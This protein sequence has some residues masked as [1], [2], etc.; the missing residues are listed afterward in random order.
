MR[1]VLTSMFVLL[2]FVASLVS[3]PC[4]AAGLESI[5][6]IMGAK[7]I[8]GPY[9]PTAG[10]IAAAFNRE[11][12]GN[13]MRITIRTNL[14][15]VTIL[16]SVTAGDFEFGVVPL[17]L[18]HQAYNGLGH[19]EG[20]PQTT[21][22]SVL[23]VQSECLAIV[24][25]GDSGIRTISDLEGRHILTGSPNSDL[26]V[27][28]MQILD[29]AGMHPGANFQIRQESPQVA[30]QLL[31]DD[32]IDAFFYTMG[33][34]NRDFLELAA[35][36]KGLFLV[37]LADAGL[38]RLI[39]GSPFL[40]KVVVKAGSDPNFINTF[41]TEIVGIKASL[42]TSLQVPERVVYQVAKA[43]FDNLDHFRNRYPDTVTLTRSTLVKGLVTPPHPGAAALFDALQIKPVL[44]SEPLG[45]GVID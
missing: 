4:V 30:P 14:S 20:R 8:T 22:R 1:D 36:R 19:W 9:Y 11:Q 12:S 3:L 37:S 31:Q 26:H 23:N 18:V 29:A 43:V 7:R 40:E 38:D 42:V 5:H 44:I 17:D 15:S 21:L 33:T 28:A 45:K 39:A 24:A 32:T 6:L 10:T 13:G 35:S 27:A 16:S 34:M 25:L 41:D 2:F